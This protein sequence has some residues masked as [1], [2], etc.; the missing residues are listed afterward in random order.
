MRIKIFML[1]TAVVLL[2]CSGVATAAPKT[3]CEELKG[4]DTGQACQI[5]MSDPAYNINIS[6][7]SYYPDQKSLENYI[8]QTRDKFLSAATSS[9]P[10]EAPYEL[11]ITSATYQSAI[12]PRGTQAVVLKV[13]QNAGG[14]HP[15]TTYKAFDWDQ[16]YRKPITYDTLW[17]GDTDPLPVVFPIVQGELSKQ[18]GQ[19]VSIAPN[20]GL[21]PVNYQNF[22]VTND[23]VIFFFNPGELL[24]E[25]AGPTQVL[26]PGSAIDSMLA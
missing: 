25:A 13:Y 3:Y 4:T 5:Q 8:A 11:N 26:V 21:D 23:G 18:T 19:Q 9:T 14:T 7:P 24:P 1:V 2:C 6:L 22:A 15:T 12:P 20:A 10:R 16:A 17:Q